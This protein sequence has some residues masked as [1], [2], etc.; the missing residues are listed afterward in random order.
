VGA[1]FVL[2][3]LIW[4]IDSFYPVYTL[5][6]SHTQNQVNYTQIGHINCKQQN[7]P[8]LLMKIVAME[9]NTNTP[10]LH[11]ALVYQ[12]KKSRGINWTPSE[13]VS[14]FN[15]NIVHYHNVSE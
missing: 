15:Y 1:S 8:R 12:I 4:V 11:A 14:R 13:K 5:F 3:L 10:M 9:N 7:K 2:V 6:F